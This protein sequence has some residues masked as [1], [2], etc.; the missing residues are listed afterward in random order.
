ME[1][2][3]KE[4][5]FLAET[6]PSVVIYYKTAQKLCKVG[7]KEMKVPTFS[8]KNSV[9]LC[10][11]SDAADEVAVHAKKNTLR[12]VLLHLDQVKGGS[13]PVNGYMGL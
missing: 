13:L 9:L 5:F 1:V 11:A 8:L 6:L 7:K 10:T 2:M 12:G 4:I 3:S